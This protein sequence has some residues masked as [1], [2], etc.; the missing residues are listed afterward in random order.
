M[1]IEA[2]GFR[3]I[4]YQYVKTGPQSCD[5]LR[6]VEFSFCWDKSCTENAARKCNDKCQ[7]RQAHC[8]L[9]NCSS[10]YASNIVRRSIEE[11]NQLTHPPS[12]P[13]TPIVRILYVVV[14]PNHDIILIRAW[15]ARSLHRQF[16]H[17]IPIYP[18]LLDRLILCFLR[19]HLHL[20]VI[21]R[22]GTVRHDSREEKT[23][24]PH[25]KKQ[26]LE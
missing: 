16:P 6:N 18:T 2:I 15:R 20:F 9:I 12:F 13:R 14:V 25:T 7:S 19:R 1:S 22:A 11:F 10:Q 21:P 8:D 4:T 17:H 23:P 26:H 24:P 3:R 5:L